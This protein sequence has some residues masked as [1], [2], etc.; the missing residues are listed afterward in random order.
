MLLKQLLLLNDL[1]PYTSFREAASAMQIPESSLRSAIHNLEQELGC[2]LLMTNQKGIHWTFTAQHILVHTEQLHSKTREL[3]RLQDL[4]HQAFSH[5]IY[6]ASSSQFGSLVLTEIITEIL[7]DYPSAQFS[8]STLNNQ[9]LLQLLISQQIDLALLQ[10]HEI[11]KPLLVNTLQGL[12]LQVNEL[13]QDH[14]CFLTGPSHPFYTKQKAS[15]REILQCSRL[16]SK[17]PADTLTSTFFRKFDYDNT[18]L[19]ISNIISQRKLIAA[20][21]YIS[22]QSLTA[23]QNSLSLYHDDLHIL[24]IADFTWNC[25]LYSVCS[26]SPTF[27]ERI[28]LEKLQQKFLPQTKFQEE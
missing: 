23:A 21:N 6:I 17:D 7:Q 27:G 24:E 20:T 22:W 13:A 11:E 3:Y 10:L 28:F 15:L 12:S 26:P 4:L 14:I 18:I 5:K 19:Q 1:K 9:A 2:T 16:V 8:L 25:T